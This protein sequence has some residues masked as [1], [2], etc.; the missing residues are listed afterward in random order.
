LP[1]LTVSVAGIMD[2]ASE[3]VAASRSTPMSRNMRMFI[4]VHMK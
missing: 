3:L 2:Q 1:P 4:S